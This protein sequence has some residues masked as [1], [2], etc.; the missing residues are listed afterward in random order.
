MAQGVFDKSK[1]YL[2]G[3]RGISVL[4]KFLFTTFYFKYSE[5]AFGTYS[6]IATTIVLLVFLMGM[7]FYSYANR[8]VLEP[9]SHPQ[10][11]IFN[12]FTLYFILYITLLPVVY[13]IF[14]FEHFD[15]AYFPVFYL[16]LITEHL[17]L[18]FYRLMFVFKKPLAAN[19][20][21]FLRNALWVLVATI[22]LYFNKQIN[23]ETVLN[24]W[25][26][27]N[28]AALIFSLVI[29]LGKRK[30]IALRHFQWDK[31]WILKGLYVSLPYILVSLAYKTIEF[32]DRYLIDYFLGKKAVGVYA[33]FA[34]MAN[35]LNIVLFTL[36]VSVLYPLLVE[37]VMKHNWN[38]FARIYKQFKKEILYYALGIGV[39][40]AVFLPL[41][42]MYIEKTEYLS[43]IYIFILLLLANMA[44]NWSFLYHFII[45]AF[46]KDWKIFKA[47]AWAAMI[48]IL[49]NIILIP[50]WGIGGAALATLVSFFILVVLKYKDAQI[51]L[52]IMK[53]KTG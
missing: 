29:S 15:M 49:L 13:L 9:D 8:A 23:I 51:L 40:L 46:K 17:N 38:T 26:T 27:G 39:L 20:N 41:I 21:L 5:A 34:N 32:S 53:N 45:Y 52:K 37:S 24:L 16:V 11:I 42:L 33:F 44:L 14:R 25:L 43:Q 28:I 7:D 1:F 3:L 12:Q 31:A 22:F 50:Y 18:E 19:I 35:V 2:I 30:K 48:N 4:A 6:L 10:K 36:V 47:T